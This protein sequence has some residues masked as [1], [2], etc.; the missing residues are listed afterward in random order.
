MLFTAIFLS[1]AASVVE[2]TV[3]PLDQAPLRLEFQKGIHPQE[4]C[5]TIATSELT[6]RLRSPVIVIKA[7]SQNQPTGNAY[8]IQRR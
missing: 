6:V 3:L 5:N 7:N 1:V 2:P 8:R 4:D